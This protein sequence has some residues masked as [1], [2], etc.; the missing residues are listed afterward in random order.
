[1]T[2][3]PKLR[4][5]RLALGQVRLAWPAAASGFTV[6]TIT[7]VA[8]TNWQDVLMSPVITG[9]ENVVTNF[10]AGSPIFFRLRK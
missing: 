10:P 1:V 7:N 4:V 3:R 6:Q 9:S 5:E 2:I 8:S